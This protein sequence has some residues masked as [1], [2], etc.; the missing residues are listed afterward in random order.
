MKTLTIKEAEDEGFIVLAGP[1]KPNPEDT[2][3]LGKVMRDMRN[4]TSV[5]VNT[6]RGVEIWRHKSEMDSFLRWHHE[7]ETEVDNQ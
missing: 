7:M 2:I 5:L 3:M 6:E 4:C 1:Y